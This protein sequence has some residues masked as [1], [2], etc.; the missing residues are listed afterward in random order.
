[1]PHWL[2]RGWMVCPSC[3]SRVSLVQ[4][5]ASPNAL[6]V[7][8]CPYRWL[9]RLSSQISTKGGDVDVGRHYHRDSAHCLL[10]KTWCVEGRRR[11]VQPGRSWGPGRTGGSVDHPVVTPAVKVGMVAVAVVPGEVPWLGGGRSLASSSSK[12]LRLNHSPTWG[13]E[14]MCLDQEHSRVNLAWLLLLLVLSISWLS[15][16]FSSFSWVF[17]VLWNSQDTKTT[18]AL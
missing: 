3:P 9:R 13:Q 7:V 18:T 10:P 16:C 4:A 12:Y 14:L 2:A 17:H 6:I 5:A 8:I 1:M 15:C 11:S